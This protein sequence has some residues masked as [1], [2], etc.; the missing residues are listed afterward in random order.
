MRFAAPSALADLPR[1][2]VLL[3]AVASVVLIA[4][5]AALGWS[6]ADDGPAPEVPL[7]A[8]QDDRGLEPITVPET[9]EI[10]K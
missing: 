4:G 7:R 5:G 1:R 3:T 6:L 2:F 10:P 9:P 8:Q